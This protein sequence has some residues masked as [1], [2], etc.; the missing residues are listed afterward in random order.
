MNT[1]TYSKKELQK[2]NFNKIY[3]SQWIKNIYILNDAETYCIYAT[4]G[5]DL[6][7]GRM[8]IA[9]PSNKMI[10]IEDKKKYNLI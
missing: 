9:L 5:C 1:K 4:G 7:S 2:M 6:V 10:T 3:G 8:Y